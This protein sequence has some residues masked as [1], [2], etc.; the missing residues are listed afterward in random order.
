MQISILDENQCI[1]VHFEPYNGRQL[2]RS[3]DFSNLSNYIAV[4]VFL[5]Y[6]SSSYVKKTTNP[7][8]KNLSSEFSSEKTSCRGGCYRSIQFCICDDLPAGPN[9]PRIFFKL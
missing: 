4:D 5:D 1:P 9:S 7:F 8:H 2:D 3:D 6:K